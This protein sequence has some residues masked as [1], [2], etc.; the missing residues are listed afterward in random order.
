M[1]VETTVVFRKYPDGS[2]IALFPYIIESQGGSILSYMRIGQHSSAE[3]SHVTCQTEM[4]TEDEYTPLKKELESIGYNLTVAKRR[5]Y[6]KYTETL[7][8]EG[9]RRAQS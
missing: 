2:I 5:N 4:A 3:Y 1:K 6:N 9:Q 7:K 8:A